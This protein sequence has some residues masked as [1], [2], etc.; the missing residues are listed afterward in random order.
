MITSALASIS[1]GGVLTSNS[2]RHLYVHVPF[3]ARRCSYCDFSIAV[4]RNVPVKEYVTALDRELELRTPEYQSSE[5]DTVYIGGGTPSRLGAE[6]VSQL[7]SVITSRAKLANDAEV[8]LEVNPDDISASAVRAWRSAGV[9]RLSIGIQSFHDNVLSWMHRNHS[10]HDAR[11]AVGI[12]RD[13]GISAVS[14]DLIFA[15]PES[16]ERDWHRDVDGILALEPQHISLYGLTIEKGTPLGAWH[17]R[18]EVRPASDERYEREF[19]S[20]HE[21][22]TA[23]GFEHYEVS[24]FGLPSHR[25]RHNSAYWSGASY[26]GVGPSAHGF[27][28]TSRRWNISAYAAWERAISAGSDPRAGEELLTAE[29]RVAESV[30]LSLRTRDGLV[31]S[32]SDLP[33]VERWRKAGWIEDVCSEEKYSPVLRVRCTPNGWLR[34]DALAA[35][36]TLRRSC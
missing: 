4:R 25:A 23:A 16:L 13:S 27:D 21:T 32:E 8:T 11:V 31:V 17:A 6:G 36:L 22:L 28:G 33:L 14:V 2:Y 35:D 5:F 24:N 10:A 19:L 12:A 3:C 26:L 34:L 1:D 20:A 9:N 7:V 18:G 29:N 30:Y 15:L